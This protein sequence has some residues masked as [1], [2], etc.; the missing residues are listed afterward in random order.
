MFLYATTLLMFLTGRNISVVIVLT[1]SNQKSSF[2]GPPVTLHLTISSP[3][4]WRQNCEVS[5]DSPLPYTLTTQ[6]TN[7]IE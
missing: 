1:F 5:L 2:L 3:S 7:S 6:P 4:L